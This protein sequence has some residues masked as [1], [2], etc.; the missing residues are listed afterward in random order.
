MNKALLLSLSFLSA[1]AFSPAHAA[2]PS[3]SEIAE[4][5]EEANDAEIKAGKMAE[6][7]ASNEEVKN[8]AKM[9]VDEHKESEKEGKKVTKDA[10]IKS[11]SSD[12]SKSFK[13]DASDKIS[14]LR[15]LKGTEFDKAYISSQ[16]DM[17]QKLLTDLETNFI[18]N[19]QNPQLRS[20]LEKTKSHVQ[21]HLTQAKKIQESM[22]GG[23]TIQNQ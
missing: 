9:M 18:P 10:K 7:K 15:S 4:V 13:K 12:L 21:D 23:T 16:I 3:D 5:M 2:T 17:H 20:H 22:G 8:Y 19:T 1:L 14:S 11:K 6:K